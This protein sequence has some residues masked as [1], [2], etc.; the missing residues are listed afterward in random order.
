MTKYFNKK[1]TPV[2]YFRPTGELIYLLE[3]K[4]IR[5]KYKYTAL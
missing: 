5:A 3:S 1:D 4:I 2:G